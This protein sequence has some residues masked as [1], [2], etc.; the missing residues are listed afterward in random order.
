MQ[1]TVSWIELARITRSVRDWLEVFGV[2]EPQFLNLPDEVTS[3]IHFTSKG[4]KE[5][6]LIFGQ[7]LLPSVRLGLCAIL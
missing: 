6:Q 5:G 2:I 4:S 3:L 7:A 1:N